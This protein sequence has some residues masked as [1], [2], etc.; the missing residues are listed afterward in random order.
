[1]NHLAGLASRVATWPVR[2]VRWACFAALALPFLIAG[3]VLATR[4]WYPVLDL[5][6]TEL[7]VRD[8][9]TRHTPLIGLPGRIGVFPDQGSHPGPLSF[10]LLAPTYR[11]LGSSA[12]GLLVGT[13]VL[14]LIAIWLALWIAGRRGGSPFVL[15]VAAMLAVVVHGYGMLVVSQ[16]WNPYLPLLAWVVVLLA[17]WSVLVGDH[18]MIVVVAGAGS[19]AGQTHLPYL[20]LCGGMAVVGLAAI[21]VD[22]YRHP[23]RRNLLQRS[24]ARAV[25]LAFV[26]WVPVVVDQVRRT[27]GNLSMLSDYFRHPPEEPVGSAEG[28]RLLLRHLDLWR[29]VRGLVGVSDRD[30]GS[31]VQAGFRLDGSVLPGLLVLLVWVGAVVVAVRLRHRAL[32]ALHAVIAAALVLATYSMS[33]IFGKVWYYL[34]LWAWSVLVLLVG[35]VLWTAAAAWHRRAAGSAAA[36]G[37]AAVEPVDAARAG[38][39]PAERWFGARAGRWPVRAI[40]VGVIAVAGVATYVPL[41]ADAAQVRAPEQHLSDSLRALVDPTADALADAVGAA[42]AGSDGTYVVT[43]SDALWFGS[44]GYGLVSELERRWFDVGVPNTWRVPVTQHRVIRAGEATAEV[45]LATGSYIEQWRATPGAV[46]VAYVEPRDA[47]ELAEY[48]GLE[49]RL[50]DGLAASAVDPAGQAELLSLIGTNLFGLQLDPRVSPELQRVVNR[51]LELG[52]P[53][54]VFVSPVVSPL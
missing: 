18:A 17:T 50:R 22:W 5:A 54:A 48:A 1:M 11:L 35:A 27:P 16:P 44:Q 47:E 32:L 7:R 38:T 3:I 12:W 40:A 26:L 39:A 24:V 33:R 9:G 43:W 52:Q 20:G 25:V 2:R 30:G 10:Y 23:I 46:E 36:L 29:V 51:M 21:A 34:T 19:F 41:L 49:A 14:A 13:I 28:V 8:V 15:A 45:H 37:G 31:F 4:H 6:M 53:E 42:T